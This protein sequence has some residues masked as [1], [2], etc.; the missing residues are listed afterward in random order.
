MGNLLL[1]FAVVLCGC[2]DTWSLT[3]EEE[4][5][6]QVAALEFATQRLPRT[7]CIGVVGPAVFEDRHSAPVSE[8]TAV[9]AKAA[10]Q[11]I[12]T[13]L[14]YSSCGFAESGNIV[15]LNTGEL[16]T[17][18]LVSAPLPENVVGEMCDFFS[19]AD[20]RDTC[21]YVSAVFG[22]IGGTG[23][24]CTANRLPADP[25]L[26]ECIAIWQM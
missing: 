1:M 15:V 16:A 19:F 7:P 4:V 6:I 3:P 26:V 13:V 17:Q 12:G 2:G 22:N 8:A 21:I 5:T 24:S 23:W 20:R 25:G 11:R 9:L 14:P 18:M 10:S